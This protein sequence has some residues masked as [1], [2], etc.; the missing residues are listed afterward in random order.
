MTPDPKLVEAVAREISASAR[1][2]L[3][4]WD[5]DDPQGI[6]NKAIREQLLTIARA[7]LAVIAASGEWWTAPWNATLR[8]KVVAG[9]EAEAGCGMGEVWGFFRD[10]HLKDPGTDK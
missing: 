4:I 3:S 7:A 10:A 8:M 1:M 2:P 9:T 5:A 6:T